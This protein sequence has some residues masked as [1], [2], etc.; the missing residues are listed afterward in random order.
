MITCQ[1]RR[2]PCDVYIPE[3]CLKVLS[4]KEHLPYGL[5]LR[6]WF[7]SLTPASVTVLA[8][9]VMLLPNNQLEKGN[10]WL[11]GVDPFI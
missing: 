8:L 6:A 1:S 5:V 9:G 3:I 11:G 4:D 2:P 7:C 10:G